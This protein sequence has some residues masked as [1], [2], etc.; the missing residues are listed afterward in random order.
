MFVVWVVYLVCSMHSRPSSRLGSS[1]GGASK[2]GCMIDLLNLMSTLCRELGDDFYPYFPTVLQTFVFLLDPKQPEMTGE[3]FKSLSVQFKYLSK[4]L[5]LDMDTV[6]GYYGPLLANRNPFIRQFAAESLSFLLRKM[7]LD[8]LCHH[9]NS[10]LTAMAKAR[11]QETQ[12]N[13]NLRDGLASLL[14][15]VVKNVNITLHSNAGQVLSHCLLNIDAHGS[16]ATRDPDPPPPAAKSKGGKSSGRKRRRSE[17]IGGKYASL[18]TSLTAKY[19]V[20]SSALYMICDHCRASTMIPVWDALL[21]RAE[22]SLESYRRS[23]SASSSTHL[24]DLSFILSL[25]AQAVRHRNGSRLIR[26]ARHPREDS[27][28][29]EEM[30]P[31][32]QH[33]TTLSVNEPAEEADDEEVRVRRIWRCLQALSSPK[34]WQEAIP[35]VYRWSV[36]ALF[37]EAWVYAGKAVEADG[38]IEDILQNILDVSDG[39]GGGEHIRYSVAKSLLEQCSHAVFS[40]KRATALLLLKVE[41]ARIPK[42]ACP[43]L[44]A[45]SLLAWVKQHC[46]DVLETEVRCAESAPLFTSWSETLWK[47]VTHFADTLRGRDES[48]RCKD[49]VTRCRLALQVLPL[50]DRKFA[51]IPAGGDDAATY[52][53]QRQ[54]LLTKLVNH[55]DDTT[56][57]DE[58]I[59]NEIYR[60]RAGALECLVFLFIQERKVEKG[61]T[62]PFRSCT[63]LLEDAL[64]RWSVEDI[65]T[66]CGAKHPLAEVLAASSRYLSFLLDRNIPV[67]FDQ[68]PRLRHLKGYLAC[69]AHAIRLPALQL[70]QTLAQFVQKGSSGTV[71]G[72]FEVCISV[73]RMPI[74]LETE[75]DR[76]A[77]MYP[78][79]PPPTSPSLF[80]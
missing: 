5:I 24:V 12:A 47:S 57:S 45:T 79:P 39:G 11:S 42:D 40:R 56:A 53:S 8:R 15:H 13:D 80:L 52:V 49:E 16:S 32:H 2:P 64:S 74:Q 17:M 63:K 78:P 7:K 20:M 38:T 60:L 36:A 68:C 59:D 6:R 25:L 44:G 35:S 62:T 72:M 48:T 70:L 3:I 41:Q 46:M 67:D 37:I 28:A 29:S 34:I 75:R 14:F 9:L 23:S 4:R 58:T 69:P 66:H 54:S 65:D 50:F 73:E 21:E 22:A 61:G 10:T 33:Q 77:L 19:Q 43:S 18:D 31:P 76:Q 55:G 1:V 71:N 30:P 26:H 27:T 51:A